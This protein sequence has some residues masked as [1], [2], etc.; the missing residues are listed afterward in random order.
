MYSPNGITADDVIRKVAPTTQRKFV[1]ITDDQ[2][3]QRDVRSEVRHREY[4][5]FSQVFIRKQRRNH[6]YR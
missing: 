1:V 5:H 6:Q 4:A 3:I 2:A